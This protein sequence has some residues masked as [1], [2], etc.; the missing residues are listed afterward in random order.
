ML[1]ITRMHKKII[2]K[3]ETLSKNYPYSWLRQLVDDL[4]ERI[5]EVDAYTL[6]NTL[7]Q[8]NTEPIVEALADTVVEQKA[9]TLMEILF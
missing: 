9:E 4:A 2:K 8:V 5:A 1:R 7:V 6:S 3:S